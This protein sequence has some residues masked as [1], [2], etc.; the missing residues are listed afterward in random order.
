VLNFLRAARADARPGVPGR[1]DGDLHHHP[2]LVP[3][4]PMD[5]LVQ[6]GS[7]PE[8]RAELMAR[9]GLDQ[10][11]A[12]AVRRL[13]AACAT[14]DLGQAIILKRPVAELIAE[15]LPHSLMLGGLA[16]VFSAVVGMLAGAL[17]AALRKTA[18]S[19]AR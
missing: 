10:A 5:N 3:G 18:G 11:A 7:S 15:N 6:I 16:F 2:R 8:Q 9:H 4:D 14:G 17:A 13:A 19:T 1:V 12:G